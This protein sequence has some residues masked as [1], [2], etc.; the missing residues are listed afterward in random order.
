MATLTEDCV[1]D[2]KRTIDNGTL[3]DLR[4]SVYEWIQ[5][6]NENTVAWD[7]VILKTYLHACLR[8]KGDIAGW[9]AENGE[10]MLDPA[11]WIAIRQMLPYGRRL[12]GKS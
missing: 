5:E 2:L 12:L 6:T 8:K 11:Q 10:K 1:W 4:E 7:Y 9:I 3:E